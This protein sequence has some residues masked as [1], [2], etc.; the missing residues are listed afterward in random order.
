MNSTQERLSTAAWAMLETL[1]RLRKS[2]QQEQGFYHSIS[3]GLKSEKLEKALYEID[4]FSSQVSGF[5]S[6]IHRLDETALDDAFSTIEQRYE[7]LV[8]A[9]A[10][11]SKQ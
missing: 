6:D 2:V 5:L 11:L 1:S 7:K 9:I 4:G 8:A 3:P 10:H